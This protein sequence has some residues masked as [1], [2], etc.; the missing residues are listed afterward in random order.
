MNIKILG[1][2]C[3]RCEELGNI[4]K[5]VVSELAIDA[6]IAHVRDIKV[7]M[8]YPILTTPGLVIN[9]KLVV[10]GRVPTKTEVITFVT[11]ALQGS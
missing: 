9:E 6:K 7:I 10:S 8:E 3:H 5:E 11:N 2:G 1:P 4:T